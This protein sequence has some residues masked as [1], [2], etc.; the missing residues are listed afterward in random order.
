MIAPSRG[1]A[2]SLSGASSFAPAWMSSSTHSLWP[3]ADAAC[4]AVC[5][6]GSAK[7]TSTLGSR[8][9]SRT[10]CVL[11]LRQAWIRG[12]IA[13]SASLAASARIVSAHGAHVLQC[14]PSHCDGLT[15]APV[16]HDLVMRRARGGGSASSTCIA[17]LRLPGEGFCCSRRDRGDKQVAGGE[18][19]ALLPEKL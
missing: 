4:N 18:R 17:L 8:R 10:H 12:V 2:P 19:S 3:K 16:S 6:S 13:S 14:A 1:V 5:P 9:S 15:S 7:S 11:P